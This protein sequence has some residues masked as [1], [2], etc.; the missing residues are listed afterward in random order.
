MYFKYM[1]LGKYVEIFLTDYIISLSISIV[2]IC[3]KCLLLTISVSRQ[4]TQAGIKMY[5]NGYHKISMRIN[6]NHK[7]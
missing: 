4:K 2:G 5:V 3:K 7:S 1:R 6:L